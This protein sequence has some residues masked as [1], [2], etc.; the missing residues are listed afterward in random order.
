MAAPIRLTSPQPT[1]AGQLR[2]RL[3][4]GRSLGANDFERLDTYRDTRIDNLLA[5]RAAGIVSGL[6]L[7]ALPG[8]SVVVRP[9]LGIGG[10]GRSIALRTPLRTPWSEL[11]APLQADGVYLLCLEQRVHKLAQDSVPPCRR[12]EIDPRRDLRFETESFLVLRGPLSGYAPEPVD[13]DAVRIANRLSA[14]FLDAPPRAAIGDGI[15]L[16]LAGVTQQTLRWLDTTAGRFPAQADSARQALLTQTLTALRGGHFASL[17]VLPPAAPLPRAWLTLPLADATLPSCAN[18]PPQLQ[19]TLLPVRASE[20]GAALAAAQARGPLR[21]GAGLADRVHLLLGVADGDFRADLL[22]IP[23]PDTATLDALYRAWLGAQQ[24]WAQARSAREAL[25]FASAQDRQQLPEEVMTA[26]E[27][28]PD[29]VAAQAPA[30]PGPLLALLVQRLASEAVSAP[31]GYADFGQWTQNHAEAGAPAAVVIN[32]SGARVQLALA[33]Q[34]LAQL[35]AELANFTDHVETLR[36][37]LGRQRQQHDALTAS[38]AGLAG[39]VASDGSGLKIARWL[40]YVTLTARTTEPTANANANANANLTVRTLALS[41]NVTSNTSGTLQA[42]TIAIS[43][44]TFT[45]TAFDVA[46]VQTLQRVSSFSTAMLGSQLS[47]KL[48]LQLDSIPRIAEPITAAA[49]QAQSN[50]FGVLQHVLPEVYAI[51]DAGERFAD[52]RDDLNAAFGSMT[53]PDSVKEWPKFDAGGIRERTKNVAAAQ[54]YPLLVDLGKQLQGDTRD[55][56]RLRSAFESAIRSRLLQIGKTQAQIASLQ[57]QIVALDAELATRLAA[58]ADAARDYAMAQALTADDWRAVAAARTARRK[59]LARARLFGYVRALPWELAQPLAPAVHLLRSDGDELVPGLRLAA[60]LPLPD[61][62]DEFVDALWE[63]PVAELRALQPLLDELPKRTLLDEA[64]L[65]RRYRLGRRAQRND[66]AS[67]RL[68][69]LLGASRTLFGQYAGASLAVNAGSLSQRRAQAA[70]EFAL[71]DALQAPPGKLRDTAAA[72]RARCEQAIRGLLYYARRLPAPLLLALADRADEGTLAV[73]SPQSWPGPTQASVETLTD[74]RTLLALL[75]WLNGQLQEPAPLGRAALDH[76][77]RAIVLSA[78][79]GDVA[80]AA[81]GRVIAA[82]TL[83]P[84]QPLRLQLDRELRPG[85][86]LE[87]R[88]PQQRLVGRLRLDDIDAQGI[89]SARVIDAL[90]PQLAVT[91]AF[92]VS[93][94]AQ[95]R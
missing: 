22:S 59:A 86:L 53:L 66:T 65:L 11:I 35:Q 61:A 37:F 12:N 29:P 1:P 23:Q 38:L 30:E 73:A 92:I 42:S 87:L 51:N 54:R 75:R 5:G 17:E 83:L 4:A 46:G 94:G 10:G 16:G 55:I 93:A 14:H 21:L 78:A 49:Y 43:R 63:I 25:W 26:L 27:P 80:L 88:D 62:L 41:N 36:D 34:R 68:Q 7:A 24:N 69:T 2:P 52:L 71:L 57:T 85:S 60:D 28:D 19:L 56:E 95:A 8:D 81:S 79:H 48:Q 9:G 74:W 50:D 67:T 40:P 20:F 15:A 13:G 31:A 44:P 18:L 64:I 70:R 6:E 77:V 90:Q 39:G 76:L 33:A 58:L 47:E 3:F 89:A 45:A 91:P 72:L 32:G 82:A 84:A